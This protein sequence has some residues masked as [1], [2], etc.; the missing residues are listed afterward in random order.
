MT[1]RKTRKRSRRKQK[2]GMPVALLTAAAATGAALM[3]YKKRGTRGS[4]YNDSPLSGGKR[5]KSRKRKSRKRKSRKRKS[6]K[7]KSRKGGAASAD[8]DPWIDTLSVTNQ[9]KEEIRDE[10]KVIKGKIE[11]IQEDID[12]KERRRRSTTEQLRAR[13]YDKWRELG[14]EIRELIEQR[15]SFNAK[16]AA[17]RRRVTSAAA[18]ATVVATPVTPVR[19]PVSALEMPPMVTPSRYALAPPNLGWGEEEI[20][21]RSPV[22]PGGLGRALSYGSES[23][24]S[25]TSTDLI[26]SSDLGYGG[27]SIDPDLFHPEMTSPQVPRPQGVPQ[28]RFPTFGRELFRDDAEDYDP[29]GGSGN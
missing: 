24:G 22:S 12:Q 25:L 28:P 29:L 4:E 23:S 9:K 21:L 5:R 3:W 6:R 20:P 19:L 18:P 14:A 2:G 27:V 7:R 11:K 16:I 13:N 26:P 17:L 15:G 10:V 8:M 1:N